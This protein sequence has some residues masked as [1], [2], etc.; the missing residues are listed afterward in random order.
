MNKHDGRTGIS[1]IRNSVIRV[2]APYLLEKVYPQGSGL[3]VS[4][5]LILDYFPVSHIS[6]FVGNAKTFKPKLSD[7]LYVNGWFEKRKTCL[8]IRRL[9]VQH[10]NRLRAKSLKINLKYTTIGTSS[11]AISL[12]SITKSGKRRSTHTNTH[13]ICK[14]KHGVRNLPLNRLMFAS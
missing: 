11:K 6:R 14:E 8:R 4:R 5:L 9:F 2:L 13:V 12:D 7:H 10:R 3:K 1:F